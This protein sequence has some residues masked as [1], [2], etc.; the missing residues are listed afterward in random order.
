MIQLATRLLRKTKHMYNKNQKLIYADHGATTKVRSEVVEKMLPVLREDFGNPS[1][2]HHYGRKAKE[3]LDVARQ[4][5]SSV[6]NAKEEEIFFTS[7]GTESDNIVILGVAKSVEEG[8]LPGKEKHIITTKIEHPAIKEPLEYLEK[9][10]W[11]IT[12]LNVDKEGFVNIE[13]FKSAIS[14]STVLVSI[15]HA[16]NE[17]GTIQ[18]LNKISEICNENNVLFHTDAVQSFGKIPID[19]S[20]L[21]I[22]FISMS[23]H[24]I[25]GPKGVGGL[26][27]RNLKNISSLIIGGGQENKI[28]PGTE[29]LP[30]IVGFSE[31]A[32]II[33]K[34]M[35]SSAV[36]LRNLQIKLMKGLSSVKDVILTGVSLEKVQSNVPVEKY[37]YRLP[38]HVSI[39]CKNFNGESLVL[40][41]DLKGIMASSG[42]A[43]KNNEIPDTNFEPSHVLL[44]MGIKDEYV[45]G[46]L[47]LTLGRENTEEDVNYI[48]E[49]IK[50]IIGK[51]QKV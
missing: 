43:C 50:S 46:S 36:K 13:E 31:A 28:R 7:G 51:L 49:V 30:G 2:I 23:G 22:D 9:R 3:Y 32:R 19:V 15:I 47:R 16:N 1:S 5:V 14:P 39:C 42:S 37:L 44:A 11:K 4:E 29:N 26:Y 40:Q 34:E 38:G 17:I 45:K 48:V 21:N 10:N 33:K 18:D 24:K 41:A 25:Y 20:K 35:S 8:L 6:I 12:W 27:I